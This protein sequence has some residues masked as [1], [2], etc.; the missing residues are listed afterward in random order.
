M[1]AKALAVVGQQ[2]DRGAV[3]QIPGSKV[4]EQLADDLVGVFHFAIVG[5]CRGEPRRRRIRLVRLVDVDEQKELRRRLSIDPPRGGGHGVR[6]GTLHLTERPIRRRGRQLVVPDVEPLIDARLRPQHVR[7]H[8]AC[9]CEPAIVQRVGQ[10]PFTL[11]HGEADVVADP[12]LEG[13]AAGQDRRV[14]RQRLRRVRVRLLEHHC[15][16]GEC[17]EMR[18][19]DPRVAVG[20]ET[21]RAQ[22]VDRDQHDRTVGRIRWTPHE[23][24]DAASATAAARIAARARVTGG[25]RARRETV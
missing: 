6:A 11:P 17:I 1:I 5:S 15:I 3:V 23:P 25:L 8:E 24:H 7:R 20:G 2:H 16:G 21:V 4:I 13:Q 10:Q 22:G 9:R 18:R 12:V 19:A 14:S